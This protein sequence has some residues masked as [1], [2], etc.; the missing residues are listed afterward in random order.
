MPI[1]NPD[2]PHR[3]FACELNFRDGEEIA[4]PDLIRI[5]TDLHER[6][7]ALRREQRDVAGVPEEPLSV[8]R[9]ILEASRGNI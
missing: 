3:I 8:G 5:Q 6:W 2:K 4:D 9:A 1:Y 7:Q